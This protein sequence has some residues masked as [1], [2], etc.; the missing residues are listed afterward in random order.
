M[1]LSPKSLSTLNTRIR[2]LICVSPLVYQQVVGLGELSVAELADEPLLLLGV[3]VLLG[4]VVVVGP[5][6]AEQR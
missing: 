5:H 6:E 2:P 1:V 3:P 4:E